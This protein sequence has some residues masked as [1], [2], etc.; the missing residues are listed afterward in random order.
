VRERDGAEIG[1]N[2]VTERKMRRK[3]EDLKVRGANRDSKR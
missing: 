1:W 2:Y 3:E